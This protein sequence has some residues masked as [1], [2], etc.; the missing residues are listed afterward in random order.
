MA[1][2]ILDHALDQLKPVYF[3]PFKHHLM[4]IA[5]Y[6]QN[7]KLGKNDQ[8]KKL[9]ND[10]KTIG[11]CQLDFYTG[12]LPPEE[13]TSQVFQQFN[14]SDEMQISVKE[15]NNNYYQIKINDNS[16]WT[17]RRATDPGFLIH[18]HPARNSEFS[19]RVRAAALKTAIGLS[20]VCHEGNIN[21][22]KINYVRKL[23]DTGSPV[24]GKMEIKQIYHMY[25]LITGFNSE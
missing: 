8:Y 25:R 15:H 5:G 10:L 11:H 9:L 1:G 14:T 17:L 19:I 13:I 24:G 7:Y 6:C 3:H 21:T 16:V 2:F 18:I 22:E 23:L 4:F 20:I 12:L